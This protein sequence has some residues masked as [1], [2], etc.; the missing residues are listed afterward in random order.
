M[1][2]RLLRM[3][4]KEDQTGRAA[5][6]FKES[7]VPMCREQKGYSGSIFLCDEKTSTCLPITLWES[8][9][10]MAKTEESRFFQEQLVKFMSLFSEP[11]VK[12]SFKV[13][14]KE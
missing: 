14:F 6:I 3:H 9:E 5:K 2:A 11:P 13:I 4:I 12:E 1:F 7:V 8:E 10:D